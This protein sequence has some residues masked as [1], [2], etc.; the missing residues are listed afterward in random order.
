[1]SIIEKS[2]SIVVLMFSSSFTP[3]LYIKKL[4]LI[5]EKIGWRKIK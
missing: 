4:K 5:L 3:H 2:A 1:M